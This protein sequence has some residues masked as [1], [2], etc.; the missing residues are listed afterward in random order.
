M[1]DI[2][3]YNPEYPDSRESSQQQSRAAVS[4]IVTLT[5]SSRYNK[6]NKKICPPP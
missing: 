2:P 4:S 6:I 5:D 1:K 3:L